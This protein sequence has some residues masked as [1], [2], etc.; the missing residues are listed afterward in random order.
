M[1]RKVAVLVGSLRKES[2]NRKIANALVEIAPELEFELVEIGDLPFYNE[3]LETETPPATW[4]RFRE[5]IGAADGVLL[6]S[7]EYNRGVPAALKNAID[8]GSRP[9]GKSVWGGKPVAI[10]SSSQGAQGGFGAN[11][12]LRPAFVFAGAPVLPHEAYIGFTG[13]LFDENGQLVKDDTKAFLKDFTGKFAAFI[14][15]QAD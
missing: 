9:W 4:T 10:I 3:D 5:Q 7:P 13:G 12:H 2:Y 15:K 11:H 14:D 1:S 6:V 8:V